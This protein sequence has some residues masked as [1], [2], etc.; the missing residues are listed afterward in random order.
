MICIEFS[1]LNF[2][3]GKLYIMVDAASST[4]FRR[5]IREAIPIVVGIVPFGLILGA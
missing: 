4:E 5:G 3:F 2:V 1:F